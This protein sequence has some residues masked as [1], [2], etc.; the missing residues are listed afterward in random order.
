MKYGIIITFA[1]VLMLGACRHTTPANEVKTTNKRTEKTEQRKQNIIKKRIS[2]PFDFSYITNL[3]SVDIIYTQGNYG[4]EVEGDSATLDYL[5]TEFDSNILTVNLQTDNNT[6]INKYGSTNN[7]KMYVSAPALKCVSIC[8]NGNFE[9]QATWR[10]ENIQLGVLSTGSM[11]IGRVEC[12][13]F[14]L[15]STD[16]GNIDITDLQAEDATLYSRSTATINANVN[17]KNLIVINDGKQTMKLTGKAQ[18]VRIKNPNDMN[19]INE[20]Q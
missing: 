1:T 16:I 4:I 19:L 20:L 9:S 13:T 10:A 7:I 17:V 11:K 12:T 6:D 14:D 2:I 5:V 8:G 18:T 15:Q 3:G